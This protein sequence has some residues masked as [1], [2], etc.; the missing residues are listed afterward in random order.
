MFLDGQTF[1]APLHKYQEHGG[2]I[3]W[4]EYVEFC[5]KPKSCL[6]KKLN[7]FAFS[8]A[9]NQSSYGSIS[10][11]SFG[12]V[13]VIEVGHS[14]RCVLWYLIVVLMCMSV[15]TNDV[16]HLFTC[17]F[18]ICKSQVRCLLR[19]LAYFFNE[20]RLFPNCLFQ[21][22]FYLIMNPFK[23]YNQSSTLRNCI[24]DGLF[25]ER[26]HHARFFLPMYYKAVSQNS[27]CNIL[28]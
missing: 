24:Q 5:R 25:L 3:L 7:H 18:T 2:Q 17:L 4:Y 6:P 13:S 16:E 10:S 11:P 8:P 12:V 28:Q 26:S 15:I 22:M 1:S 19:S 9:M 20:M 27:S 23:L 21:V 14:S